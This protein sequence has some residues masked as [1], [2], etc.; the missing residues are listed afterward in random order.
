[1]QDNVSRAFVVRISNSETDMQ[2]YVA[3]Q[4]LRFGRDH[5]HSGSSLLLCTCVW[6]LGEFGELLDGGAAVLEDEEDWAGPPATRGEA[7]AALLDD[8]TQAQRGTEVRCPAILGRRVR[9]CR[10]PRMKFR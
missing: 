3:R 8:L 2:A 1:M 4:A 10:V 9:L 5:L 7:A 6:A